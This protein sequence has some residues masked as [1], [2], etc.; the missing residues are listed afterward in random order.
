[1]IYTLPGRLI[2]A[3]AT[4]LLVFWLFWRSCPCELVAGP[5]LPGPVNT[6]QIADWGFA[7]TAGVCQLEVGRWIPLSVNLG[8][9]ADARGHL[10]ISCWV[11]ERTYWSAR[12][13]RDPD[14]RIRIAG[15]VYP[16]RLRRVTDPN[17][18]DQAWQAR[19]D[20][21]GFGR[22]ETRPDHWWSFVATSRG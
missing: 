21:I 20:K 2:F 1:M 13:L 6:E 12:A 15:Q 19:T 10:Y 5:A 9:M 7:N 18:L 14:A 22:G 16:V 4:L 3:A 11:C 17:I 8:C